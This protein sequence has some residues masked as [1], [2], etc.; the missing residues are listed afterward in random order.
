MDTVILIVFN[1]SRNVLAMKD[2][3]KRA[4]M[5]E[6]SRNSGKK[7]IWLFDNYACVISK[8][9]KSILVEFFRCAVHVVIGAALGFLKGN[10]FHVYRNSVGDLYRALCK[11]ALVIGRPLFR[12]DLHIQGFFSFVCVANFGSVLL[13]ISVSVKRSDS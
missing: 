2:A 6:S 5:S 4:L 12:P 7:T 1:F 11:F 9:F 10:V 3:F 13:D 8:I